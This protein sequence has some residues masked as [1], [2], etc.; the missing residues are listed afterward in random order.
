MGHWARA[1]GLDSGGRSTAFQGV[2]RPRP[3]LAHP[4]VRCLSA[5]GEGI[6]HKGIRLLA[7]CAAMSVLLLPSAADAHGIMI[8]P[9]QTVD[10]DVEVQADVAGNHVH[11]C[12]RYPAGGG[13]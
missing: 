1:I 13:G 12:A 7:V 9:C 6:L 2:P 3:E 10:P 11:V 8:G 4:V 5:K